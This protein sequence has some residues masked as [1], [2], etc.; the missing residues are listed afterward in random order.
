LTTR[1]AARAEVFL[2]GH[3]RRHWKLE[4]IK[5]IDNKIRR[6]KEDEEIEKYL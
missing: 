2:P 1:A 5:W 6:T 3:L 4:I